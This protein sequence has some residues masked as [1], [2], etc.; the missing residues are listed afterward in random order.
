[1]TSA[2]AL[3]Q[4]L[5]VRKAQAG[6]AT[7]HSLRGKGSAATIP[8]LDVSMSV[9]LE[10]TT[11]VASSRNE[12]AV[13]DGLRARHHAPRR[14]HHSMCC[15][16]SFWPSCTAASALAFTPRISTVTFGM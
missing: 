12:K 3:H 10:V 16:A 2:G 11:I 6:P 13:R 9:P 4:T 8:P 15:F 7:A 5:A 14:A 1:M